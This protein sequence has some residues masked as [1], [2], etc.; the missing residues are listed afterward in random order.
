LDPAI[1]GNRNRV[2][3]VEVETMPPGPDNEYANGFRSVPSVLTTECDARRDVDPSRARTWRIENP[4]STNRLGEPV[5]YKLLPASTPTLHAHPDAA[6]ARRAAFARHNLW[7]TPF[8]AN[9]RRAAGEYPN[10]S[11]GDDGLAVWTEQDRSID[12]TEIVVWHTFGVTHLVR[13]EDW[14]VMPVESTGFWLVPVGF[15]ERNPALDVPPPPSH[16]G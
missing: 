6:V 5:A 15:F 12:D 11:S 13:P 4:S 2:V 16:C 3:E 14:P 8:D 9:Q 1:D 10:Q 7:V